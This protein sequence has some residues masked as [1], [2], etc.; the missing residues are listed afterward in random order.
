MNLDNFTEFFNRSYAD[1]IKLVDESI[2]FKKIYGGAVTFTVVDS[3]AKRDMY[4]K[5][6]GPIMLESKDIAEV[7]FLTKCI[8]NYNITK[9]GNCFIFENGDHA[10]I[11]EKY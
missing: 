5:I 11:L 4:N 2:S 7:M 10:V 3:G 1:E 6:R 8:G 9:I